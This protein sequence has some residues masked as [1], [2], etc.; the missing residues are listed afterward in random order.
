[1]T[2]GSVVS[3]IT[4]SLVYSVTGSDMNGCQG[5]TTV[6]VQVNPSPSVSFSLTNSS[7]QVWDAVAVYSGGTPA[8]TYNWNWGDGSPNDVIAYPSHT[9]SVA[10]W[11]NV[12]VTITDANACTANMCVYDSLYKMAGGSI[13]TLN[14]TSGSTGIHPAEVHEG[15]LYPNPASQSLFIT[16][17]YATVEIYDLTGKLVLSRVLNGKTELNISPLPEGMYIISLKGAQGLVSRKLV[18]AR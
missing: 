4:S 8:Y 3:S 5:T 12:C 9:Y 18:I 2:G 10:G 16:S 7:P 17:A 6:A 1:M 15:S 11:Y 14:V 13:I